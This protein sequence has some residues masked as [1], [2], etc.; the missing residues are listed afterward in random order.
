MEEIWNEMSHI[1]FVSP[2]AKQAA[3]NDTIL[4]ASSKGRVAI[5]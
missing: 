4:P 1:P 3:Q 2:A 5:R